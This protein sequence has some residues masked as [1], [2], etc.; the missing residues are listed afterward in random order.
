[1]YLKNNNNTSA[2][3]VNTQACHHIVSQEQGRKVCRLQLSRTTVLQCTMNSCVETLESFAA[4]ANQCL[5]EQWK[6]IFSAQDEEV[7]IQ[8][9]ES[10]ITS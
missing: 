6:V 5:E 2:K 4:T 8:L 10:E 3:A 7:R 1:M 9:A